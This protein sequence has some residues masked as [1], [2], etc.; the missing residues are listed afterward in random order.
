MV[1]E[2]KP[3]EYIGPGYYDVKNGFDKP[4]TAPKPPPGR[5]QTSH[6]KS[7]F[8]SGAPRFNGG[9]NA[10]NKTITPAPGEYG[11]APGDENTA[12]PWF[13]RSY[14]MLFAL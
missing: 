12:N 11:R 13:K 7:G 6:S 10:A 14:N 4:K 3:E 9:L 8:N 5:A 2:D 1:T